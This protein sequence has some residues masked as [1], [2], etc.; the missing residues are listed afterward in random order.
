MSNVKK[1]SYFYN[2]IFDFY[3]S[4]TCHRFR[5]IKVLMIVILYHSYPFM[6]ILKAITSVLIRYLKEEQS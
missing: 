1:I 4:G 3:E 2:R 6:L 5:L